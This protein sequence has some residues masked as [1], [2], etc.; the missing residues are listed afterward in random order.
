M[1]GS[2]AQAGFYYQNIIAAQYALQLIEFG[3]QLRSITFENPR[4]AKHID[5]IIADHLGGTTFVQVKWSQDETS[6][7]TLHNLVAAEDNST[8]LLSKLARGYQQVVGESGQKEVVLLST[9]RA[10]TNRQPGL[11]FDKSL[12]EY[13]NEFHQPFTEAAEI[14]DIRQA[15][16]FAEYE[17]TLERL[18]TASGL[19]DLDEFSRFLK[20]LRFRLNEPD[21]D[22]MIERVRARLVQLGIE[23]RHYATLLDEVIRWSIT[24]AEV[25]PDDVRRVLGVHDRF[26]DRISHYFPVDRRVWV[27]TSDLFDQLD[28]SIGS[29]DS[30]FILLEGEPGSGKSTALTMYLS[31]RSDVRFGYYCF[32]PND[33]TLG[34]ERLGDD[35]FV[36]SICIGLKNAFPDVEFPRP[37][38]PQTSQLLSEWLHALSA[39]K[40]RVVF[41]VDGLD[42]VDR[43]TRQSLVARPL[44]MVLDM[45]LPSNVLIVLSSRY[46][47]ALPPRL[48]DHMNS[49]SK[50]HIRVPRFRHAQVRE[51]FR[52]RGVGLADELL[53]AVVNV[54]GGVPIY[55]EY[56][57]DR[58]GEMN[59]YQQERYL[60]SVPTLRD[61]RIDVYHKHLWETCS[62]DERL[63]YILA[64]L[65]AR[66]EFTTPETLRELLQLVGVNSTLHA[67]H[68]GLARLRHVLRVSDAKSVAIRH[69]SLAEFVAK[70]TEYLGGEITRAIVDWYDRNPDSDEAWRH[71]IRHLFDSGELSTVLA[72]TDDNWLAQAWANHRPTH[73]IQRNLDIAWR[74]AADNRNVLE[75]VRIGL[76]KHRIALVDR[77]LD[78]LDVDVA[79][80]LLDMG[81]PDEALRRVWDGERRQCSAVG[82][83]SF[84]LSHVASTGRAPA[85]YILDAG[86]GDG[87]EQGAD[88]HATKTWYRARSFIGDPVEVLQKIGQIRWRRKAEHRHI[89]SPVGE[90]ENRRLNLELQMAVVRELALHGTLDALELVRSSGALP[91]AVHVAACASVGFILARAGEDLDAAAALWGLDLACL[92]EGDQRWFFLQLAA[93][94]VDTSLAASSPLRPQLPSS[95]LNSNEREIRDSLF[96]LYDTLRCFFLRDETGFP[97][98]E[99]ATTG[100]AEPSRTLVSAIG[101]LARVWTCWIRNES[102]GASP[103][104]LLKVVVADLDLRSQPFLMLDYGGDYAEYLYRQSVPRFYEQAWSCAADVL[105][106]VDLEALALWW[107]H[108]MD[109]AAFRYSEATRSLAMAVHGRL[110]GGGSSVIYDLLKMAEWSARADEEASSIGSSLMACASAWGRCGFPDAAQRIWCELLDVACGVYWRKDYQFN[111]ILTALKL[112]H[113]QDPSGTLNRVSEQLALAH[114]LVGTA[115]TKTVAVAIE[116]L[117]E[118]LFRV[119]PGLALEALVREEHL[120]YRERVMEGCVSVLLDEGTA[121]CRLLIALAGTMGRWENY[122]GFDEHTKPTMFAV[123][124]SAL[125]NGDIRTARTAYDLW[126]HVLLVEKQMPGELGRW[127]AVWGKAG[128]APAEVQHD[129]IQYPPP[130]EEAA[131]EPSGLVESAELKAVAEELDKLASSD[132][133]KL[134]TRLD[135]IV[136]DELKREWRRGLEHVHHD[137]RAALGRVAARDWSAEETEELDR[138]FAEFVERVIEAGSK[139]GTD[140]KDTVRDALTWFVSAVSERLS[141]NI[142]IDDFEEFFDIDKWLDGF[143][144]PEVVPYFVERKIERRLSDWI[145]AALFAELDAWENFCSQ[146]CRGEAR[147]SGLL[148][149]AERRSTINW[150]RAVANLL[151]SW[152]S[153]SD[154]FHEYDQ[155]AHRICMK[156]LDLDNDKG[157]E[158]L[159]ESFRRQYQRYPETIIYRLDNLLDFASKLPQFNRVCLYD[160]WS[161]HN[162]DLA[163]GLSKKPTDLSWL[164]EPGHSS[165]QDACLK[166]LTCLFNY[167]VVDVRLLAFDELFR[168]TGERPELIAVL[169]GSWPD[170][171]YGQKEYVA[172]LLFS[173]GLRDPASAE[174]WAP[175]LVELGQR[176]RH[177]N[178]RVTIA[179]AV[180]MAAKGG[181]KLDPTLLADASALK[182]PP[183]IVMAKD[184][185]LYTGPPR[186]AGFPPYLRR[187]LELLAEGASSGE[188]IAHMW[189]ILSRLYPYPERGRE[190]EAAIHRAYNINTNF[191]VIEISGEYDRAV[192]AALNSGVQMLID[193]H[194]MDRDAL[195]SIEDVLRL[196]D[197]S[198]VL[199]QRVSRPIHVTWIDETLSDDKFTG[200]VDLEDLKIGYSTRDGDWVTVFEYAEQR[201]GERFGADPQRA[202]RVRVV[203]FGIPRGGGSPTAMEI[204]AEA[205]RGALARLRNRYRFELIHAT[206]SSAVGRIIPIVV[207]TGRAFR[208]RITPDLA[209]IVPDVVQALGLLQN[210]DDLLGYLSEDGE[211]VVRSIEWQEAFDQGRRRHEPRSVGYLI[212]MKQDTLKCLVKAKDLEFWAYLSA[213]RTTDRYKPENQMMRYEH[214]D[215]FP[216]RLM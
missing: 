192:R 57:A 23:Q 35:A 24:S 119:D 129:L 120:I 178:L 140:P 27:P 164:K 127:A 59:Y 48:I 171:D 50:R 83:A 212:Q 105:S 194:A 113:E 49:D 158:L 7:F 211:S 159:F 183:H 173:A 111:E 22:T 62:G 185:V 90:E 26:V 130:T 68:E 176:E 54:S 149:L 18:H 182:A 70:R 115:Q 189:R 145:S 142:T 41:V 202:T 125:E 5:D 204:Q 200:F 74:A 161:A 207:V 80:L 198:D 25:K 8:S 17:S 206:P 32:V 81:R 69:S 34:N 65:A 3:T 215:V 131:S 154:L 123:Y 38:A 67:V 99:A 13:I 95:L 94:R 103:L 110:K 210:P 205:R 46:P 73:E 144:R 174:Q 12:T 42:H 2:E 97:W 1:A 61:D 168:L 101:R 197:P 184:P 11:G 104:S 162:R 132:L 209:A 58:L 188:L 66:D 82:F 29:L 172:T 85:E 60:K 14:T 208:G 76:L 201:T 190:E 179:E 148:A 21:R 31:A 40:R 152:E 28:L 156:L 165:F 170:L 213:Q 175:Q 16:A 56:L 216:V 96:D 160:I 153:I 137:W 133:G 191:D 100:L 55:L 63:V 44:T 106:E 214:S 117:I 180:K 4:R 177:R 72:T 78:L 98:F 109:R 157:V 45:D 20:C 53:E 116:G 30:G 19:K 186:T 88:V 136:Q 193:S 52:L 135:E 126:R 51:F 114:Q 203:V 122:R 143:I 151:E 15:V 91:E 112:A 187:S 128:G 146:Y 92:P 10:G 102:A 139:P 33:H 79:R 147:A 150:D 169:L 166:Y 47:E 87:P 36:R 75:F 141:C 107:A 71:R 77:N 37:Y 93:C 64:I 108:S 84:C 9:R 124:S 155:L 199:V 43:K 181:A 138:S 89:K 6:A 39:T 195:K 134:E 86:L 118:F 121:D 167:P 196:R 163:A